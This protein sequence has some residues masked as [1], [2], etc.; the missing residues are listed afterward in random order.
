[1][2][3]T[4]SDVLTPDIIAISATRS[5]RDAAE[6]MRAADV[7]AL[8]V[9][10]GGRL[11]GLVIDRDLV[12]RVLADGRGLQTE[13]REAC[14]PDLVT[15]GPEDDVAEAARVMAKHTVRRLPVVSG[16]KVVGIVSLGD[17]AIARDPGSVVGQVSA[18]LPST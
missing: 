16:D 17:L 1:M 2:T 15:V 6:L 3:T 18:G 13:V 12:V 9:T 4:V 10:E 11:V 5:V 8:V 7:G 14:S